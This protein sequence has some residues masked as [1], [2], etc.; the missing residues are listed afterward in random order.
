MNGPSEGLGQTLIDIDD[1]F[2]F[3][4]LIDVSAENMMS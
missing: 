2:Q 1:K 3:M 4:P